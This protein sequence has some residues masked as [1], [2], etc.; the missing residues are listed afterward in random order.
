MSETEINCD[1]HI[2]TGSVLGCAQRAE[3]GEGGI[4]KQHF[5]LQSSCLPSLS[6]YLSLLQGYATTLQGF[7]LD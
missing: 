1:L 6:V 2:S 4:K 5:T 3:T 7:L